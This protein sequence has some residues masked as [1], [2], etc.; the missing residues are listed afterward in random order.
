MS[1]ANTMLITGISI[2]LL[3]ILFRKKINELQVSPKYG[4]YFKMTER[5]LRGMLLLYIVAFFGIT[6]FSMR[7]FNEAFMVETEQAMS[8]NSCHIPYIERKFNP[9]YIWEFYTYHDYWRAEYR[10]HVSFMD[11]DEC[12]LSLSSL[13]EKSGSRGAQVAFIDDEGKVA[14]VLKSKSRQR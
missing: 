8:E 5:F 13:L 9:L 2:I 12:M 1:I 11:K 7:Y 4:L 14:F 6:L 3:C 10:T